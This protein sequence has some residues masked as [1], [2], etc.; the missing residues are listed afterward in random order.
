MKKVFNT[1]NKPNIHLKYADDIFLLIDST[2]E[3]KILE[4]TLKNKSIF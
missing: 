3:I 1:M 4:E 2:G